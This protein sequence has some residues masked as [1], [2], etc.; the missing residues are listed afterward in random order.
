[1]AP[2]SCRQRQSAQDGSATS[3]SGLGNGVV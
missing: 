1:L 2:R 3:G